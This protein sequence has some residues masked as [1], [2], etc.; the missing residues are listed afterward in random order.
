[1]EA[2]DFRTMTARTGRDGRWRIDLIPAAFDLRRL[3]FSFEH[4]DFISSNDAVNIQPVTPPDK[5]RG[6][7]GVTVLRR[8]VAVTGHVRAQDGRPIA[9]VSV[10]LGEHGTA[11]SVV[12]SATGAFHVRHNSGRSLGILTIQATGYAPEIREL[13]ARPGIAPLELRLGPARTISGRVVD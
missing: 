9:G 11:R 3:H 13:T 12:T 6:S 2:Y 5:L 10:R 4:A 8:G 1:R 7:S